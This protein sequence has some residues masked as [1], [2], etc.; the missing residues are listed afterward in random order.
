MSNR[1]EEIKTIVKL[2]RA[3]WLANPELRLGQLLVC[4]NRPD[5]PVPEIF[6]ATDKK[7]ESSL[8]K[9]AKVARTNMVYEPGIGMVE[10]SV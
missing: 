9:L 6:H 8:R 3:A 2:L 5:K 4:A 7:W 1:N 10:V